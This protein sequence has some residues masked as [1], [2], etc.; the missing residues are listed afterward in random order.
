MRP[1]SASEVERLGS[2]GAP[3]Q[4]CRRF[5]STKAVNSFHARRFVDNDD[6]LDFSAAHLKLSPDLKSKNT[7]ET[8]A[9]Q[10]TRI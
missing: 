5:L 9:R 3:D 4:H 7:R 8:V 2:V 10:D 1:A 6:G